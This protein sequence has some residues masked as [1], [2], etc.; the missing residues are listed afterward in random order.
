MTDGEFKVLLEKVIANQSSLETK[1]EGLAGDMTDVKRG[2]VKL[3]QLEERLVNYKE[4]Q[5]R[6]GAHIDRVEEMVADL[7]R[8]T[9]SEMN[10]RRLAMDGEVQSIRTEIGTVDK[11]AAITATKVTII[12]AASGIITSAIVATIV[13]HLG[14]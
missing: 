9:F 8:D 1:L 5:A 12:A 2:M 10:K 6:M 7:R 14:G 13:G 11:S 4:A 3:I